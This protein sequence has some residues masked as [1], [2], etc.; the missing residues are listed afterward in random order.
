VLLFLVQGLEMSSQ[1]E[2]VLKRCY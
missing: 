1:G 2:K